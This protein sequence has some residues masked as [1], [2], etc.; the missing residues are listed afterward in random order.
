MSALERQRL[1]AE[2]QALLAESEV[3][4]NAEIRR[5]AEAYNLS[6]RTVRREQATLLGRLERKARPEDAPFGALSVDE[7]CSYYLDCNG[8]IAKLHRKLTEMGAI[9]YTERTLYRR[10]D[11]FIIEM[12][13]QFAKK[14]HRA[15]HDGAVW[16][17]NPPTLRNS[18]W[19]LDY[20]TVKARVVMPRSGEIVQ[21]LIGLIADVGSGLVPGAIV[22]A[23]APD[24]V[25]GTALVC[26][27]MIPR[28]VEL[29]G[30]DV[31][32]G[33]KP[34]RLIVDNANELKGTTMRNFTRALDI[35]LHTTR[36]YSG[37][38][39][40]NVEALN[41]LI[42]EDELNM[43][44]AATRGAQ[45]DRG[46]SAYGHTPV[47]AFPALTLIVER[48]L[49]NYNRTVRKAWGESP[50][51]RWASQ[52]SLAP[53]E[54]AADD[55][56]RHAALPDRKKRKVSG[57]GIHFN[58]LRYTAPELHRPDMRGKFVLVASYPGRPDCIEVFRE[59]GEW[60]C[61]AVVSST[62]TEEQREAC[63]EQRA[64]AK[65]YTLLAAQRA[66]EMRAAR[67]EEANAAAAWLTEGGAATAPTA[68]VIASERPADVLEVD[69][70]GPAN[71]PATETDAPPPAEGPTN[72][73]PSSEASSQPPLA[74]AAAPETEPDLQEPADLLG[75]VITRMTGRSDKPPVPHPDKRDD[76]EAG[77]A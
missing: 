8:N 21:P 60:L 19:E 66:G 32:V 9:S 53:L 6:V 22:C 10:I 37:W 4:A 23:E 33:G 2:L 61:R 18:A 47:L 27:A 20:L 40:P 3:I 72:A 43:I 1:T 25:D 64:Q 62:L 28:T 34:Q 13:A 17:S 39:K 42:Q 54:L 56:L 75:D 16:N 44:P 24:A 45:D 26:G 11:E 46:D 49:D 36:P 67:A 71:P 65:E 77:V 74:I 70:T 15:L 38:E 30:R 7:V 31:V 35:D 57:K 14:G 59:D 50:L 41:R 73:D 76:G 52:E 29:D 12:V 58:T 69:P 51:Q 5:L 55:V 63:R 48:W 68:T